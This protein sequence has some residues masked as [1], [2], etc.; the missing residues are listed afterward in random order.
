M[1][2]KFSPAAMGTASSVSPLPTAAQKPVILLVHGAFQDSAGWADVIKALEAKGHTAIAIQQVG[3]SGDKTP[4]KDITLETYRDAVVD[5]IKKQ[6]QPVILVGHSFGGIVIS[7]VAEAVPNRIKALVYLAA[8]LPRNGESLR[9]ISSQDKYSILGKEG[10]FIVAKDYSTASIAKEIFASGLCSD[11]NN[12]QLK[13]VA[14]SQVDEPLAP[15][16]AKVTL[17]DRNFGSVRK[18][19]ILTAQDVMVSPQLQALMLVNTSV[20]KVYAVNAGHAAYITAPDALATI[21][22]NVASQK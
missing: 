16:N 12:D 17:T 21:I 13:L 1:F 7:S 10:N 4:V 8:Y 3:R 15:L 5:M 9:A 22:D 19:Y 14:A 6:D 20:D 2:R 11:C 18:T